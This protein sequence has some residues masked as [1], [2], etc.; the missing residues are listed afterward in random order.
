MG[1]T[2]CALAIGSSYGLCSIF[3]LEFSPMHNFI[4]FL[5][6]GLGIDDMFVIIQAW[7]NLED[8]EKQKKA[9]GSRERT[10]EELEVMAGKCM[11]HSGVSMSV[12]S[13]TD[14]LAF[15]VGATTVLPALRSFCIYC[16]MGILLVYFLQSSWFMAWLVLD[17]KRKQ[18]SRNGLLPCIRHTNRNLSSNVSGF[19]L[20]GFDQMKRMQNDFY[21]YSTFLMKTP[22][23]ITALILTAALFSIGVWG[24]T[25]LIQRFDPMWF[26]PLD[27]Y[28]VAWHNANEHYFPSNGEKIF[29]FVTEL[30]LPEELKKLDGV[31]NDLKA[32]DD[33]LDGIKSWYLDFKRYHH[34]YFGKKR[35]HVCQ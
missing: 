17:E 20:R 2:S 21:S 11:E 14:F 32:Q 27:S 28:L 13:L 16:G 15:A 3:G 18:E 35:R 10:Q 6:L 33:I 34:D 4:P 7:S 30:E 31:L 24:N 29:V 19:R 25:L 5:I 22:I 9:N 1:L 12:T 26:L 23:K 8:E